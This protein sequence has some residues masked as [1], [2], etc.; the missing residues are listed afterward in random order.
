M[1][2]LRKE[3]SLRRVK[4]LSHDVWARRHSSSALPPWLSSS[5]AHTQIAHPGVDVYGPRWIGPDV[6]AS[7][8]R[9]SSSSPSSELVPIHLQIFRARAKTSAHNRTRM[10]LL[11][12][13]S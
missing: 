11:G 3:L 7:A 13:R 10:S 6:G 9:Q 1:W 5:L 2:I 12:T 4:P 8:H